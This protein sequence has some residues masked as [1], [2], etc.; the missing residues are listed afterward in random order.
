MALGCSGTGSTS[1]RVCCLKPLALSA[2]NLVKSA[3]YAKQSL[4]L[5]AA[6]CH[7]LCG[8]DVFPVEQILDGLNG[9]PG[10]KKQRRRCG[11]ANAAS[12]RTPEFSRLTEAAF[13]GG[14]QTDSVGGPHSGME[15]FGLRR[16]HLCSQFRRCLSPDSS[17]AVLLLRAGKLFGM[18]Q[19][20][21]YASVGQ[22]C[23]PSLEA[24]AFFFAA[25]TKSSLPCN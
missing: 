9:L 4:S 19:F 6:V 23:E 5:T 3:P 8:G 10:I 1:C 11:A 20:I 15:R 21:L 18:P 14:L 22:R 12:R 2:R 24:E 25:L 17:E 16:V 7:N 13:S